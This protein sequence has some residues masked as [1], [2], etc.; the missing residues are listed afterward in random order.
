[1]RRK[2]CGKKEEI[3]DFSSINLHKIETRLEKDAGGTK[4]VKISL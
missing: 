2:D 3:G 1:M 4:R